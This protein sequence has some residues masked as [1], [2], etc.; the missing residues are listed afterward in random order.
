MKNSAV[1]GGRALGEAA[2]QRVYWEKIYWMHLLLDKTN[3]LYLAWLDPKDKVKPV[4]LLFVMLLDSFILF[5]FK[6]PEI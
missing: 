3:W 1:F 2:G 6:Q 4:F 5:I